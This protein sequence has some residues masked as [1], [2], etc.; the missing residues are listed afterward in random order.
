[1]IAARRPPSSEPAN[2]SFLRPS[3]NGLDRPLGGVVGHF[4]APVTD[5]ARQRRPARC[6]VAEG[7]G[8]AALAADLFHCRVEE[9]AQLGEDRRRLSRAR[10]SPTTARSAPAARSTAAFAASRSATSWREL[11]WRAPSQTA[12]VRRDL[13]SKSAAER[14]MLT[15][16]AI[17]APTHSR[18]RGIQRKLKRSGASGATVLRQSIPSTSSAG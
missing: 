5:V 6:G 14:D 15:T 10:A 4:E 9:G 11:P 1:M 3:A 12:A 17:C 8:E 2:R 13:E 7:A 16:I 18:K